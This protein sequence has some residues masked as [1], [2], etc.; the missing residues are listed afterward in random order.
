[1]LCCV[2]VHESC[3]GPASNRVLAKRDLQIACQPLGHYKKSMATGWAGDWRGS[4]RQNRINRIELHGLHDVDII[5]VSVKG[6]NPSG[7]E[8][9]MP[10]YRTHPTD[11]EIIIS[12]V[13][14]KRLR[15]NLL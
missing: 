10:D 3:I 9:I 8:R 12:I 6:A 11:S 4:R 1:M 13:V 5:V 2:E 14:R 15:K 7:I